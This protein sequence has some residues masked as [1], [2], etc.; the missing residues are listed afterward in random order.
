MWQQVYKG[1]NCSEKKSFYIYCVEEEAKEPEPSQDEEIEEI[2]PTIS[3]HALAIIITPQNLNIKG[4]IKKKKVIV[5][6][7]C[8]G[9]HNFIHYKLSK[10]LN[11][12]IYPSLEF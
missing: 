7:D 5:L 8:G 3:F 6:I 11:L 10:V 1:H 12:F 4:H 2:T 9:T